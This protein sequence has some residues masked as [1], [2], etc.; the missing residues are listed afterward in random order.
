MLDFIPEGARGN[1]SQ[2]AYLLR[3]K[4]ARA[5]RRES[6]RRWRKRLAKGEGARPL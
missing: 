2:D 4:S 1:P 6:V 3:K 5:S